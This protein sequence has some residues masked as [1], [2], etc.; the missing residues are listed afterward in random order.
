MC[1]FWAIFNRRSWSNIYTRGLSRDWINIHPEK[2]RAHE[3][4]YLECTTRRNTLLSPLRVKDVREWHSWPWTTDY[5]V[6][7]DATGIST[8]S[9][10]STMNA[11]HTSSVWSMKLVESTDE[12]LHLYSEFLWWARD[13]ITP[14]ESSVLQSIVLE[15]IMKTAFMTVMNVHVYQFLLS[16]GWYG[17]SFCLNN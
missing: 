4:M 2:V 10:T 1:L 11:T 12:C 6:L 8:P 17:V 9:T 14:I 7:V 15:S 16:S 13:S 5:T 3:I